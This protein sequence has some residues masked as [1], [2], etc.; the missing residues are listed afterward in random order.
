MG[1]IVS[2]PRKVSCYGMRPTLR[3]L[4]NHW[5]TRHVRMDGEKHEFV[6]LPDGWAFVEPTGP[7]SETRRPTIRDSLNRV[8]AVVFEY[9]M[10]LTRRY[11]VHD[12]HFGDMIHVSVQEK[13]PV[14]ILQ[15]FGKCRSG[16]TYTR[17]DKRLAARTWI[18]AHYPHHLDPFAYWND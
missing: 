15:D 14:R 7:R 6:A 9:E 12:H 2:V 16:D 11:V 18:D 8:R 5:G 3:D 1:P 4:H 13:N 17:D 10:V